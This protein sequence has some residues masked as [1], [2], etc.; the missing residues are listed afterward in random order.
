VAHLYQSVLSAIVPEKYKHPK[1]MADRLGNTFRKIKEVAA[2]K[3]LI[4]DAK[5]WSIGHSVK[6]RKDAHI[7]CPLQI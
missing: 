4:N 2:R 1:L 3:S 7:T 5:D 6:T